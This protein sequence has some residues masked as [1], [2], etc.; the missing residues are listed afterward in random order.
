M[1]IDKIILKSALSTLAAIGVLCAL[2]ILAMCLIFP[3]TM[4]QVTYDM[5]MNKTSVHFASV[6]YD[7][8]G[9]AYYVAFATEVSIGK[10]YDD[11]TEYYGEKLL[12]DDGFAEYAAKRNEEAASAGITYEQ[13]IQGQVVQAKYD[14]GKKTEA[15][16]AAEVYT[17]GTFSKNC[18]LT[19]VYL[20]AFS[21]GDTQEVSNIIVKLQALEVPAAESENFVE[22]LRLRATGNR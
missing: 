13:Y 18:S 2:L 16:A 3:Q 19:T 11:K 17:A 21:A 9:E 6:A 15:I 22:L 5:G 4:M 10:N 1:R 12:G 8:S 14:Q 20:A 7:R